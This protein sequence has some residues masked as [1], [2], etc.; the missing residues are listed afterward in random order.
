MLGACV[1]CRCHCPDPLA[2]CADCNDLLR[3]LSGLYQNRHQEF[4]SL[5]QRFHHLGIYT[6]PLSG[7]MMRGKYRKDLTVLKTLASLLARSIDNKP[8]AADAT[9]MPVPMSQSRYL[10]RGYNQAAVIA[11]QVAGQLSM[12]YVA[13][14]V[15][16]TG[17][18]DIQHELG[19]KARERN[20][21][22]AF[23]AVKS[24]PERICV[25]D[26]IYTTG[27][28]MRALCRVLRQ[29]GCEYIEIWI[30]AKTL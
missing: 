15:I 27:A 28:T 10:E 14:R 12:K 23:K 19:R 30:I 16:H 6:E 1:L 18:A 2:L 26:D 7:L 29:A 25:I 13:D 21:R 5:W 9:V 24:V 20:M 11:R 22:R 8:F 3:K 4:S 17:R